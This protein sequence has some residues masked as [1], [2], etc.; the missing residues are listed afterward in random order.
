MSMKEAVQGK[1][2]K[3]EKI[4]DPLISKIKYTSEMVCSFTVIINL[5][6]EFKYV[7]LST[8]I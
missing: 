2:R 7:N 8:V 3:A 5:C 1:I 6:K 4:V